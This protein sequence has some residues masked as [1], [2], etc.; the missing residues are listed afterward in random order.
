PTI[1]DTVRTYRIDPAESSFYA[2]GIESRRVLVSTDVPADTR[3]PESL[4]AL[5]PHR[6][7]LF[8]PIVAKDRVIG[9]FIAVWW[10]RVPD[11]PRRDLDLI[12]AMGSQVGMALENARLFQEHQ[13]KLDEL[14]VL[15]EV[16]RAVTGQLDV[17]RLVYTI[18]EQVSRV[19]DAQNIVM[20]LYDAERRE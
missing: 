6:A 11:L 17:E 8:G 16:S 18:R 12:R 7:Q 14:S 10:D 20:L 1:L 3:I 13:R 15:Y 9:A 2:D 5:A 4:K 19:V